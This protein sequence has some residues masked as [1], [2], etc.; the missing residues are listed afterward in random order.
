MPKM[1]ARSPVK[2]E[3]TSVRGHRPLFRAS[4][5][6]STR[7]ITVRIT[8]Q[9]KRCI[10]VITGNARMHPANKAQTTVCKSLTATRGLICRE[11]CAK[12]E[13]VIQSQ[14]ET[15]NFALYTPRFSEL[16]PVTI[17]DAEISV[18]PYKGKAR[19]YGLLALSRN[20]AFANSV[21]HELRRIMQ[22]QFLQDVSPMSLDGVRANVESCCHFLVGLPFGQKL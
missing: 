2:R 14:P 6:H 8:A 13:P 22:V 3:A 4:T 20:D 17:Q 11:T 16:C 7:I 18:A 15:H 21:E 9:L 5:P 12:K 19:D 10:R 1:S